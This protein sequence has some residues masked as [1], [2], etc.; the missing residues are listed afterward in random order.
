MPDGCIF[1]DFNKR[2]NLCL[3]PD[4]TSVQVDEF[5]Q[6][7]VPSE[8]YIRRDTTEF[9][10]RRTSSPFF[11]M[12]SSAASSIRTTRKPACP[13]LKGTFWFMTQSAK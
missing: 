9:V 8:F 3:V 6:L 12:D 13:S 7:D 1:L 2:T 4:L 5:G 10:H 11:R